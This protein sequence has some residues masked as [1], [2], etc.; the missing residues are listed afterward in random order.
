MKTTYWLT[1]LVISA[2]GWASAADSPYT[3][4]NDGL[5]VQDN[6]TG[7]IW[8]R[9]VEGKSFDGNACAGDESYFNHDAALARAVAQALMTGQAWRL[10]NVK[11]LS[12]IAD[13]SSISTVDPVAFPNNPGAS[14][15]S[16]TPA[17]ANPLVNANASYAWRV[18]FNS[19]AVFPIDR[20]LAFPIRLVR[21]DTRVRI[22]P[23]LP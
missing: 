14:F 15:W 16:S 13:K 8:R 18:I 20:S 22:G 23:R 5:E 4:S 1:C 17:A 10:P 9:C 12:S 7:L 3:I 19:G 2:S 6:A 21:F 11:E